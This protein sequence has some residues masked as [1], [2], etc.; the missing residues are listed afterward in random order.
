MKPKQR[1]LWRYEVDEVWGFDDRD[2]PPVKVG[3]VLIDRWKSDRT[4]N[5]YNFAAKPVRHVGGWHAKLLG[6]YDGPRDARGLPVS[7]ATA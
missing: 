3:D 6:E 1:R 2:E 5:I 4:W 7:E